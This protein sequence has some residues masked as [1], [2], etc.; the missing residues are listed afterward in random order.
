MELALFVGGF[1]R[2][3]EIAARL[4]FATGT[5][6]LSTVAIATTAATSASASTPAPAFA[7]RAVLGGAVTCI[8]SRLCIIR[9]RYGAFGSRKG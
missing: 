7:T 2:S 8:E 6:L 1:A 5:I 4:R 3:G 9:R